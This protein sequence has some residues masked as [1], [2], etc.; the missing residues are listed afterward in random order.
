MDWLKG[1]RAL[2]AGGTKGGATDARH[3]GRALVLGC[4][5]AGALGVIAGE[6]YPQFRRF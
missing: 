2:I 6:N 5:P 3:A 1:K 4:S